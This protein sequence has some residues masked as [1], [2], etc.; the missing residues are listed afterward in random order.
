M[1][2]FNVFV[3]FFSVLF[4]SCSVLEFSS[5]ACDDS[6]ISQ[7]AI[8]SKGKSKECFMGKICSKKGNPSDKE[9][10]AS[11]LLKISVIH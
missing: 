9:R 1:R 3:M 4:C 2:S 7:P 10:A 6:G 5:V 8:S 11:V